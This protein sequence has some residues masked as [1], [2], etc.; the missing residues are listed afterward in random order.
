MYDP[1]PID[2]TGIELSEELL[3]LTEQ[4]AENTHDVWAKGRMEEGWVYGKV[5][6]SEKKTT[7]LLIPYGDLPENE[8][9][10]DRN[11]VLE[12]LKMIVKLGY[13][14]ELKK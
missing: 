14:I 7:P 1:K 2:T 9:M 8:K 5:K 12:T 6:D 4:I 11:T 10:Y 13:R 3:A